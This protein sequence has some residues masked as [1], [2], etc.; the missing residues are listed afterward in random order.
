M[1][2]IIVS[3][4]KIPENCDK[5]IKNRGPDYVSKITHNNIN[6]IH[7]L[8]HLTGDKTPQPIIE[9]NI[10]CIFNGEI[11]NYK[12]ILPSA[13][14]DSYSII[15]CY[16]K[17]G[18]NFIKY[19]D[20]E[21]AIVLFD[22][23]KNKLFISGDVFGTKPLFYS[24]EN[25][26][27]ISSYKSTCCTIKNIEYKSIE[28]NETLI[29]NLNDKQLIRKYKIHDFDLSQYKTSYDDYI[30]ALEKSILKRVPDNSIP[31]VTLS[32]GLDSG[33]IACCLNKHNKKALFMTIS[34]NEDIDVINNRKKILNNHVLLDL[35]I[36]EK[37]HWTKH[38]N[39]NCE[40]CVWDWM[41]NPNV[42][43]IQ[44]THEMG[45]MLGKS[46][47]LTETKKIDPTIKVLL[48]GI[49]ADEVMSHNS[50]YGCGWGNVDTFPSDLNEVFPWHNF[51]KGTMANYLRGD[52]YVGGCF[53]FETRYPFCDTD[54]VQEF[55]WLKPELKNLFKGSNYKPPLLYYLD[56]HNF[57]YC[58]HKLG[59]NV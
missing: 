46:K 14:S 48:S 54:V 40:P 42:Q 34:K 29:F 47:I 16:K 37:T 8:L 23:N 52:E 38:L 49:G 28:P 20:G 45:S 31:L 7:Y 33:A 19:L 57:P 24:I 39:L 4:L 53:S 3:S 50:Y 58:K 30:S 51:Y 10:V 6:F 17:R 1:C 11:Y 56:K 22:F 32:S 13:K 59:F 2:G 21:F 5:Y 25:D 36:D 9:N 15:D 12:Q 55:L 27:I 41:T 26:I 18:D 44:Q 35:S 43:M